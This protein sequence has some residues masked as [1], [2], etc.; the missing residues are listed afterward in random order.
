MDV[1]A[2]SD[3][4]EAVGCAESTVETIADRF[5]E[6]TSVSW[7]D[8]HSVGIAGRDIVRLRRHLTEEVC[9]S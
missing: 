1:L 4:A 3:A 8:V 2:L 7:S 5:M 6:A 9:A